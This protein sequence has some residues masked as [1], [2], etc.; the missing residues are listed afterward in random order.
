MRITGPLKLLTRPELLSQRCFDHDDRIPSKQANAFA[1]IMV[2]TLK[3]GEHVSWN[4]EAGRVR[5]KIIKVHRRDVNYE[6]Y[7]HHASSDDTLFEIKSDTTDHAALHKTAALRCAGPRG[8][9]I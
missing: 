2:K 1:S 4:S 8:R 7:N 5:G 9:S 6:G 3:I